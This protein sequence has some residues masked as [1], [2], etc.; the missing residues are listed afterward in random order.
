VLVRAL[1]NE[2][3]CFFI[4]ASLP[5]DH[6]IGRP[7]LL[8]S[9]GSTLSATSLKPSRTA[10]FAALPGE[11]Q[12]RLRR[13]QRSGVWDDLRRMESR[14]PRKEWEYGRQSSLD[15]PT[16]FFPGPCDR[17]LAG[18]KHAIVERIASVAFAIR[19][20]LACVPVCYGV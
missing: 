7:E 12:E 20:A 17:N 18:R 14:R 6:S 19:I 4:Q 2:S 10:A 16:A 11:V 9:S 15:K 5:G 3:V 8:D 13:A 1:S